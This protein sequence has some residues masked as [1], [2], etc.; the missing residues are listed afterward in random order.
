YTLTNMDTGVVVAQDASKGTIEGLSLPEGSYELVASLGA[1]I[2]EASEFDIVVPVVPAE[3]PI[4]T[5]VAAGCDG[6]GGSFTITNF[7]DTLIYKLDGVEIADASGSIPA[8]VGIH[9]LEV[10][11][12]SGCSSSATVTIV[13][14]VAPVSPVVAV[15]QPVCGETTGTVAINGADASNFTYT[16]TNMDTGVVVAQD[17]S[18]GSI[19]SIG[20]IEGLSLPAGHYELVASLGACSSEAFE[21]EIVVYP[22]PPQFSSNIPSQITTSCDKIPEVIQPDLEIEQEDVI[23]T[24]EEREISNNDCSQILERI[25]TVSDRCGNTDSFTQIVNVYCKLEIFNGLSVNGDNFNE[26]FILK[27]IECYPG[28]NVKIF[29]RWGI[30]VFEIDDYDNVD[31]SFKGISEGR[32]TIKQNEKLPS[33]TYFY[34]IKYPLI[35][36]SISNKK[37][38]IEQS[39]YIYLKD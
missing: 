27:G 20:T 33:G 11:N 29:N 2:S 37:E 22:T 23:F 24:F 17:A 13:Q 21:F 39:G 9:A 30:L 15:N 38:I 25:W 35:I 6:T 14:D 26:K 32:L 18:K 4:T 3:E 7:K 1:C 34:I 36:D 16:L 28:N 8:S 31:K 12:V 10:F 19:G 5:T